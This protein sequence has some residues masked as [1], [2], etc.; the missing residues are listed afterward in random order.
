MSGSNEA[1]AE[2]SPLAGKGFPASDRRLL[3]IL[4]PSTRM[5]SSWISGRP[6]GASRRPL[7]VSVSGT[8]ARAV[9]VRA[10][11]ACSST[12]ASIR[13]VAARPGAAALDESNFAASSASSACWTASE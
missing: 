13:P 12:I 8:K 10:V 11:A 1:E 7:T 3:N 5:M 2:N 6:T 9:A 4:R